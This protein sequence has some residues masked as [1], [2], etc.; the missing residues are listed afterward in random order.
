MSTVELKQRLIE[1]IALIEDDQILTEVYRLLE[2]TNAN[3]ESVKLTSELQAA[4]DAGLKDIENG[5]TIS[6]KQAK[7]EIDEWL[8][9]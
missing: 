5:H 9:K 3:P 8:S 1:R 4:L 2:W 7:Q 6:H